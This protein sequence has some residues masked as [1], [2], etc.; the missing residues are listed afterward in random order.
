MFRGCFNDINFYYY[1][2]SVE[3]MNRK[4]WQEGTLTVY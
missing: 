1:C 4:I 3:A 2:F